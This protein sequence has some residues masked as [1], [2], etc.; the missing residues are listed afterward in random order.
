MAGPTQCQATSQSGHTSPGILKQ[1][2]G[3]MVEKQLHADLSSWVPERLCAA[4]DRGSEAT[5]VS[6]RFRV[7][8]IQVQD[9]Q[10]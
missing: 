9:Q 6:F 1:G 10:Y 7:D 4:L 5:F 2:S 8:K 3:I